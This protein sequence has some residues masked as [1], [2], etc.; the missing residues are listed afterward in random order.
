MA[1]FGPEAPLTHL[2]LTQGWHHR[3]RWAALAVRAARERAAARR[4]ALVASLPVVA[5]SAPAPVPSANAIDRLILRVFGPRQGPTAACV[6]DHESGDHPW[7]RNLSGASGLMQLMPFWWDGS[8]PGFPRIDPL[9][10]VANVGRA[11]LIWERDGWSP[12]AGDPCFG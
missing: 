8:T 5:A 10:P 4:A 1:A 6:A 11:H 12:W 3:E 7:E 9:D 2:V